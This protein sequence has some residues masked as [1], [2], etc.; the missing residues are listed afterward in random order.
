MGEHGRSRA[1]TLAAAEKKVLGAE[2]SPLGTSLAKKREVFH[3]QTPQLT[4]E[5]L[6][7]SRHQGD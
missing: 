2:P 7:N 5:F 4:R 3:P 6:K 1:V